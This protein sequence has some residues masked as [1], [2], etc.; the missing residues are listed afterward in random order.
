[1]IAA[2]WF[3]FNFFH[4]IVTLHV[5]KPHFKPMPQ[6]LWFSIKRKFLW[7]ISLFRSFKCLLEISLLWSQLES[8]IDVFI[9][10]R[11]AEVYHQYLV[12]KC[13]WRRNFQSAV[14]GRNWFIP[15]LRGFKYFLSCSRCCHEKGK[16]VLPGG[17][18]FC[19][20]NYC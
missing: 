7:K 4:E 14:S 9:G 10:E 6:L 12:T 5:P 15:V 13:F 11:I 19:H 18:I 16:H 20:A 3:Y 8:K 17:I 1:M 2:F